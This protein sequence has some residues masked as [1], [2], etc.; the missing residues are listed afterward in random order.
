MEEAK[1]REGADCCPAAEELGLL[2]AE[3]QCQQKG[4]KRA[5]GRVRFLYSHLEI[6]THTLLVGM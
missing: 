5:L 2:P 1:A 3:H 4:C 6:G